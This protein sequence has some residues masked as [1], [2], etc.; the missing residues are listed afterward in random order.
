MDKMLEFI[1][2]NKENSESK[3]KLLT[4]E[5]WNKLM[6]EQTGIKIIDVD[7]WRKNDNCDYYKTEINFKEFSNRLMWCTIGSTHE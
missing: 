6:M 7:G 5:E 4:G 1:N 3:E 2:L